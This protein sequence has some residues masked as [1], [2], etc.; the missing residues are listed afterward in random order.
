MLDTTLR[1]RETRVTKPEKN[2]EVEEKP[3]VKRF[4]EE[5]YGSKNWFRPKVGGGVTGSLE[6]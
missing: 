4:M 2:P 1:R 6:E 5:T 3:E